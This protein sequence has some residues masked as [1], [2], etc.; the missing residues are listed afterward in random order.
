MTEAA[1][2]QEKPERNQGWRKER[3]GRTKRGESDHWL[4]DDLCVLLHL[5]IIY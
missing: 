2:Q 1:L 4:K 3:A 5:I